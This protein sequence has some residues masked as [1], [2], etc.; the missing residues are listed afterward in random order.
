MLFFKRKKTSMEKE[1][2]EQNKIVQDIL[3]AYIW[4]N[5]NINIDRFI[6]FNCAY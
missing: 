5:K 6:R 1:I 4:D 3:D 2:F